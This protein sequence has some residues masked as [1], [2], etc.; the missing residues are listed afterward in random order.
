MPT[1][2]SNGSIKE[3]IRF[4]PVETRYR[5]VGSVTDGRETVCIAI[6][7]HVSFLHGV[8]VVL[9]NKLQI[10]LPVF[11]FYHVLNTQILHGT[12]QS[13]LRRVQFKVGD[14]EDGPR[15]VDVP[16]R[17]RNVLGK[18][19]KGPLHTL[20]LIDGGISHGTG[21]LLKLC[22]TRSWG[23]ENESNEQNDLS[24]LLLLLMMMMMLFV[25]CGESFN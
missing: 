3:V 14:T 15:R 1:D 11:W 13:N 19:L 8:L 4:N 5:K 16:G 6:V 10:L 2:R 17:G 25:C 23:N 21:K 18:T 12:L 22:A 7:N 20:L 24:K 9:V